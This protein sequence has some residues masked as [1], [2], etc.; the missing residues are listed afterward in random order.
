LS[1]IPTVQT[2]ADIPRHHAAERPNEVAFEFEGRVTSYGEFDRHC[3]QVANGLIAFGLGSQDRIAY[4]GK[5]SDHYFELVLGASKANVVPVSV[6]YRLVGPEVSYIL[7]NSK[8]KV[9]FVS[10]EFAGL[11]KMIRPELPDLAEVVVMEDGAF[12]TGFTKWRDSHSPD[13]PMRAISPDDTAIQLYTS[14]TTGRPKGAELPHRGFFALRAA[15][16]ASGEIS[17]WNQRAP[18]DVSLIA[19]PN[20]HIGGTGSGIAGLYTGAKCV[21]MAEFDPN[22]VLEYFETFGVS[23]LFLVPA[24]MQIVVRH[25]RTREVDFSKLKHI[26]YGASPIPLPLLRECM[27]VFDCG[28][29]QMYGMTETTGTI[30]ALPPEDHNPEGNERMRSAGKALPGVELK[31]VDS[32]GRTLPTRQVGEICVQSAVNMNGYWH[33]PEA[34]DK[35]IQA[36]NWLHTGDAG[37]LDEEGYLYIQ[38]RVKDMI[39]SGGENIYPAE[40][41]LVLQEHPQVAEVAVIGVPSERW[42]EEVKAVI[43]PEAD[44]IIVESDMIDFCRQK[45]AGFKCPKTINLMDALPRNPSGKILKKDLRAAYWQGK[46]RAVN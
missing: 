33:L 1:F 3:S 4:L 14:G 5:N 23:V 37:Y 32:A 18:G 11:V 7:A 29:I 38:D 15:E 40:V 41:E 30:V 31:I 28:F 25:P 17:A 42:G 44:E 43:V 21:V 36:G 20:F 12:E 16:A 2:L 8:A 35:T 46:E 45:I 26:A 6:N 39:V 27:E 10:A 13:D 22:L 19:M 9:L 24:A 34:T